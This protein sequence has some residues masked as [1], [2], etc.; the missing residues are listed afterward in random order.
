[1]I[2]GRVLT[3]LHEHLDDVLVAAF[4]YG[5]VAAGRAGPGN[6]IDCFVLIVRAETPVSRSWGPR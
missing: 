1:M 4:L 2:A 5:S 6:D 3:L